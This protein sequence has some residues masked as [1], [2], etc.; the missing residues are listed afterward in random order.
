V[1]TNILIGG[2]TPATSTL[3]G[4]V[5][6]ETVPACKEPEATGLSG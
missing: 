1:K 5:L 2:S 4:G 3:N 6:I